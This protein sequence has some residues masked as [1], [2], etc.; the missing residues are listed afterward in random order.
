MVAHTSRAEIRRGADEPYEFLLLEGVVE[1][2][3]VRV[4]GVVPEDN[5]AIYMPQL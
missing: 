4:R 2:S 3:V 5:L 1:L